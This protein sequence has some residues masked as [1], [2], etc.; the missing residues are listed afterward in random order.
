MTDRD[1]TVMQPTLEEARQSH[2]ALVQRIRYHDQRY[3]KE[4]APEIS[5]ADYDRL[6]ADLI[7]L[8]TLY[9]EL[10]TADS[11]TRMVGAAPAEGFAKVRHARPM[12]SLGNAFEDEDVVEFL[13]R[14]RKGLNLK[15][16]DELA[17][18]AEPKIDGLSASLRYE[19]RR[20]VVA[21]T[22]GDGTEGEDV[23]RNMLTIDD[24]P[25]TLPEDAPDLV[26]VRGE[27]YMGKADFAALNER[28][29]EAGE[30]L[31]A[32]PRNAAAGSLRQLDPEITRKRPLKFFAYAWG[33][34]SEP[35]AATQSGALDRL[36]Y[37]GF[38][39]NPLRR[40]C[41]SA[42]ELLERYR[43]IGDGR[44][45]LDYDIDGVVY[46]IDRLDW[47]A[48][49]GQVAR[50]PR[51]AI[52]HKFPAEQAKTRLLG[53]EIQVGRTGALTPVAHLEPVTVGGVVVSRATL[54]NEDEIARKDIRIGDLVVVQ[55]AGDVIPQVVEVVV[56]ERPNDTVPF[57]APTVC[58]ACGSHAVREPGEAVRRC[59]GG[60][61]CPAQAVERLKHFVS[62][63]AADIE[64]LGRKEVEAFFEDGLIRSP[65]DIYTLPRRQETG[66]I[67][68][69]K[70]AG[71]GRKSA[72]NLLAAIEA[73]RR[74]PLD[75]FIFALGI[76]HVGQNTAKLLARNYRSFE[77]WRAG[78]EAAADPE[79]AARAD[80]DAIAGIGPVVAEALT[81]FMAE[82]HNREVLEALTAEVEVI[83][84][85]IPTQV[86]GS[87]SGKTLVFTGKLEKLTRD[88]AKRRAE[89]HGATVA[90]SVSSA[91][92]ILVAGA[93][94]GSKLAKAREKGIEVWTE[95]EFLEA[96]GGAAGNGEG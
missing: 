81:D 42:D 45:A 27:V 93:A 83:E 95:D 22:R 78:L 47:Q 76:R 82:A 75:R 35:L 6:R 52:A 38:T 30:A 94:A 66:E 13:A 41:R 2:K 26:E 20:L 84:A 40:L 67:D 61:I 9:P 8:E 60:L 96:T 53:I 39:V 58:P 50:A 10:Q 14:A 73:R 36:E 21:A 91:T 79:S 19:N 68:L 4:A 1:E 51:W 88:S 80:L 63:D 16:D 54:H 44:H 43:E 11:P 25:E 62:R 65:V 32:N 31:F 3:Y 5:D 74:L 46:K 23:T 15:E 57:E 17:V 64:G 77:A 7:R 72:D 86:S 92:S 12:L 18:V 55:R 49:L 37:F 69:T 28:R 90:S 29:A 89:Q 24:V 34:V 71:W 70:R 56:A 59:T 85:D 87:L 33:E 48:L